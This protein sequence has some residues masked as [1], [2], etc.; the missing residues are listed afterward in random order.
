MVVVAPVTLTV[1]VW[2]VVAPPVG[3]KREM[4]VMPGQSMHA[5]PPHEAM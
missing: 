1:V 3:G 2:P 5:Q 4:T